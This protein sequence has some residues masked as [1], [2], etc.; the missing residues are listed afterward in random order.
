MIAGILAQ[1]LNESFRHM[2]CPKGGLEF[3]LGD[4]MSIRL[5]GIVVVPQNASSTTELLGCKESFVWNMGRR[6]MQTWTRWYGAT[7]L[8]QGRRLRTEEILITSRWMFFTSTLRRTELML[9]GLH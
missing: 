9:L 4:N 8:H 6:V 1:V 7:H 3:F 5:H 2:V